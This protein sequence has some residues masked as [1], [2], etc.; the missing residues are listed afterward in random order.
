MLLA[1]TTAICYLQWN[2]K[3]VA[4]TGASYGR[5]YQKFS[6]NPTAAFALLRVTDPSAVRDVQV[7]L[8]P[9]GKLS[10]LDANGTTQVTF[11]QS[12][13]PAS[14]GHAQPCAPATSEPRDGGSFE[15][16][17]REPAAARCPEPS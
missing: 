5:A 4:I 6:A 8:S 3:S 7:H 15:S 10:V 13:L 2:S 17:K 16:V 12:V 14:Q 11:T 9:T 1:P